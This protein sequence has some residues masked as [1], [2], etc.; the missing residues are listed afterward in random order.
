[1]TASEDG[2]AEDLFRSVCE[3]IL[4]DGKV[5]PWE[6]HLMTDVTLLLGI[7]QETARKLFS[8]C[9]HQRERYGSITPGPKRRLELYSKVLEIIVED[10]QVDSLEHR[11]F[12]G[13]RRAFQITDDEHRAQV[14]RL[15]GS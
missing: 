9:R 4:E 3:A 7:D 11:A 15:T 2:E 13:L 12:E 10:G 6:A 5:D 14:A 1:M 8:E